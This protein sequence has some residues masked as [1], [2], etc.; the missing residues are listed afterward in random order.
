MDHGV[1]AQTVDSAQECLAVEHIGGDRGGA[2][3]AH[4]RVRVRS[5]DE[6]GN[7]VP[8]RGQR[9]DQGTAD[10]AGGT[11]EQNLHDRS[12]RLSGGFPTSWTG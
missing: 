2:E 11:C 8:V 4:E 6:R 5:A 9:A 1:G 7:F 10:G 3:L 12:F